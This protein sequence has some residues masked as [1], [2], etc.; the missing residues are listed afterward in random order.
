MSLS[1]FAVGYVGVDGREQRDGLAAVA[2]VAFESVP[3]VRSFPV[4]RGQCNNTGLWWS[5]TT[6]GH[7]GFES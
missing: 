1:G 6:G 4:Y 7:V 5:A 3:P 2:A